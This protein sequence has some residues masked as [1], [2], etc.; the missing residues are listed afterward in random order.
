MTLL[1]GCE[2]Q[3]E[4]E[5]RILREKVFESKYLKDAFSDLLRVE[6][7][8]KVINSDSP[9]KEELI[10]DYNTSLGIYMG[11]S[12]DVD[13]I[14]R[15]IQSKKEWYKRYVIADT[16]LIYIKADDSIRIK[17]YTKERERFLELMK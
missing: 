15:N 4:K 3:R 12:K 5:E 8:S 7:M 2:S 10:L 14:S 16:Y 11:L 6:T 13:E 1:T 9:M 17:E